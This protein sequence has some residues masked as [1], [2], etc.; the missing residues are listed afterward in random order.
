[1]VMWYEVASRGER[2]EPCL[3]LESDA[4]LSADFST[5]H[6]TAEHVEVG[7][8]TTLTLVTLFSRLSLSLSFTT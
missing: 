7:V 2:G 4:K 8:R 5:V 3:I 1:M 6:L